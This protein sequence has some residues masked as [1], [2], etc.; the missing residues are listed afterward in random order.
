M[1]P[2]RVPR[3]SAAA[4]APF[5]LAFDHATLRAPK[6]R[7]FPDTHWTWRAGEQWAVLAPDGAGQEC[8]V[9][10]MLGQRPLTRGEWHPPGPAGGTGEASAPDRIA[11]LS[12]LVQRQVAAAEASFYQS[13]WHSG[14]VEGER[15]VADLLT[16]AS[17]EERNPFEVVSNRGESTAFRRARADWVRRLGVAPLLD[18]RLV[19][20][21]NGEMRRTLL[22]RALLQRPALLIL[23]DPFAGLDVRTRL[24]LH[25]EIDRLMRGGLPVLVFTNR[26]AD[27][28]AATTHLLLLGPGRVVAQGPKAT[29]LRRWAGI[30]RRLART[31]RPR[32]TRARATPSAPPPTR[33]TTDAGRP[34]VELRDVTVTSARG[35]ILRRVNWTLRAGECWAVSGPNGAGKTTLLNLI[36]GDHPQAYAHDV[37]LFGRATDSTQTLWEARRRLGWMSPELHQYHPAGWTA[38]EVVCS[39]YFQTLGLYE[40]CSRARRRT[41]RQ[42]LASLGLDAVA[43]RSF[44]EL[45]FGQQRLVLL[46]RAAIHRPRLLLLDEPCQGLDAGQRAVMLQAIDD[47]VARTGASLVFVTHRADESPRCITHRL[48]VRAGRVRTHRRAG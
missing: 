13:R 1:P 33:P 9:E 30:E 40:P 8:L 16:Q 27:L 10:A 43:G 15:R 5:I 20:L 48:T 18:R 17:V 7:N 4:V 26:P 37:R 38:L 47:A 11:H 41:A 39:G 12:P 44:W 24:R 2:A 19:Q 34:L 23:E 36:Q 46:A 3:R 25:R 22:V 28:P 35:P 29:M 32:G 6:D 31:G 21:S 42:W 14:V 45:S